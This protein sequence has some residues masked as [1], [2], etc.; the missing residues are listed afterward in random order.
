MAIVDQF[1]SGTN[2]IGVDKVLSGSMAAS[3]K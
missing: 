3:S 1:N 2:I